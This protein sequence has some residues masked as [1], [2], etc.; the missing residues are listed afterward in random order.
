MAEP[1]LDDG[2]LALLN[3]ALARI[4]DNA[5]NLARAEAAGIDITQTKARF[6]D[7]RTKILQIKNAF[8]P[9]R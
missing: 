4:D 8:F 1:L 9:G 5:E 7:S 6:L 3:E 2:D